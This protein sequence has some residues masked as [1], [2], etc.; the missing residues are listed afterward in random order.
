M[1]MFHVGQK[2]VCVRVV[3]PSVG[4]CLGDVVTISAIA[5][6][7]LGIGLDFEERPAMRHP[8]YLP[9]YDARNFRPVRETSIECF[10]ALLNTKPGDV[11]ADPDL[12]S[13]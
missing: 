7:W 2:V 12:V 1:T 10:R 11:P 13:A 9:W 3:T 5:K 4:F 8:G 6:T